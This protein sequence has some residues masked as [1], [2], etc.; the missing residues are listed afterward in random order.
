MDKIASAASRSCSRPKKW[1]QGGLS[2]S[3]FFA[4]PRNRGAGRAH[5]APPASVHLRSARPR[6]GRFTVSRFVLT[7]TLPLLSRDEAKRLI[8]AAGGKVSGSVSRKTSYLVAGADPVP[9]RQGAGTRRRGARR[10]PT[11]RIDRGRLSHG[12]GVPGPYCSRS[13]FWMCLRLLLISSG[14]SVIWLVS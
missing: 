11:A 13:S 9:A 5:C 7:G 6:A 14:G 3:R 10:T 12:P 4:E 8:E 1:A 2:I